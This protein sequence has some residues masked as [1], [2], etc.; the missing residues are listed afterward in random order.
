[1]TGQTGDD[2]TNNVEV[3]VPLK[4]LSY[5]WH[6]LEMSLINSDVNLILTWNASCIIVSTNVANQM[7]H[8]Q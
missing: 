6:T 7:Q 8:L 4:N 5:F 1:M 3:M 2:G